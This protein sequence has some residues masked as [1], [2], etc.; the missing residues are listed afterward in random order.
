MPA[1]KEA[2]KTAKYIS[3]I[4]IR[5]EKAERRRERGR[6]TGRQGTLASIISI[7]HLLLS[8]TNSKIVFHSNKR[9]LIKNTFK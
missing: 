8:F 4:L 7:F 5:I 2:R 6:E 1:K 3:E 9:H